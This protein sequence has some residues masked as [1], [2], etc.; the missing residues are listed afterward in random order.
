MISA[1]GF[2]ELVNFARTRPHPKELLASMPEELMSAIGLV[3][4]ETDIALRL[5]QYREAGADEV[6]LVPATAGDPG[7]LRTLEAMRKRQAGA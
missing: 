2:A 6:C 1:A 7:G 3:G 5:D 4:S